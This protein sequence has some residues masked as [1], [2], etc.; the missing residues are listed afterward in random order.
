MAGK[1]R[2]QGSTPYA[3]G[4]GACYRQCGCAAFHLV[5]GQLRVANCE[6]DKVAPT[7]ARAV[8][9]LTLSP[10]SGTDIRF[11]SAEGCWYRLAFQVAQD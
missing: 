1:P 6:G 4:C 10:C 7:C 5:I 11:G 8:S 3:V 9:D 2:W